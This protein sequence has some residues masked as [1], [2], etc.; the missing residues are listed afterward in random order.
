MAKKTD[1]FS[2]EELA[3]RELL[4]QY[5][6][7]LKENKSL[8]A[9]LDNKQRVANKNIK[10]LLSTIDDMFECMDYLSNACHAA[11]VLKKIV[12]KDLTT[13]SLDE[14]MNI[15]DDEIIANDYLEK[16]DMKLITKF[17]KLLEKAQRHENDY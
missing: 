3:N 7:L 9:Q 14:L 1:K 4:K 12:D 11:N 6:T 17:N 16:I 8:Q 15:L 2:F 10:D 5:N 13:L